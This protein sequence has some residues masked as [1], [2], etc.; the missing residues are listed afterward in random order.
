MLGITLDIIRC[1]NCELG[2]VLFSY[3]SLLTN[4]SHLFSALKHRLDYTLESG[5]VEYFSAITAHM[6]YWESQ[7]FAKF[8][9]KTIIDG[10]KTT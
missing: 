6:A 2:V 7:E 9:L 8:L 1:I 4:I 3:G 10:A 5:F